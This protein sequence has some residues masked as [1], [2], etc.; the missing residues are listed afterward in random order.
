M[1]NIAIIP[2]AGIREGL[3]IVLED[4]KELNTTRCS[5]QGWM[6]ISALKCTCLGIQDVLTQNSLEW[7]WG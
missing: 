6:V 3:E 2:D 4:Y 5:R 1:E 7:R